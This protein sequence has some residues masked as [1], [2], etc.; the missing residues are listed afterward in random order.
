MEGCQPPMAADGVV[1][2]RGLQP[3]IKNKKSYKIIA[4]G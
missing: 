1:F 3:S 4:V 2:N